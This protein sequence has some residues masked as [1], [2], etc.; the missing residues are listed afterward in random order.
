MKKVK[1]LAL[2][3][4]IELKYRIGCIPLFWQLFKNLY[5]LGHELVVVPYAGKDL[6]TL[7]WRSYPNPCYFQFRVFKFALDVKNKRK[8]KKIRSSTLQPSQKIPQSKIKIPFS[9]LTKF[10]VEPFWKKRIIE[11]FRQEKDFDVVF[12][13]NIPLTHVPSLGKFIKSRF[14]VK[15]IYY[16]GDMPVHL[17]QYGGFS[18]SNYVLDDYVLSDFDLVLSNSGGVE[19][20][21]KNFGAKRVGTLHWG[22]DPSVFSPINEKK[23]YDV[24]F[25]GYGSEFREN[26]MQ[27]LLTLPSV[28]LRDKIFVIG[29]NGF[30]KAFG[31]AKYIG[32]VPISVWR[33]KVAQS[34]INL[35]IT[36]R[37]HAV[38]PDTSTARP[39][40]LA[41]MKACIV[42]NNHVGLSQWFKIGKEILIAKDAAE[43]IEIYSWLLDDTE[44]RNQIAESAYKRVLSEHTYFHRA[45]ELIS[46]INSI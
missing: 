21:L 35:N 30:R 44:T 23:I 8:R 42:S 22:I 32:E 40:E 19:K 4:Y 33:R 16:D 14:S 31:Y 38:T 2:T 10:L 34:K 13:L 45:K 46:K 11:I 3:S 25:Y 29:G 18:T 36:R 28:R 27:Y 39:F 17:P 9:S 5:E 26:D 20:E 15:M 12:F 37:S 43:A 24:F 1:I 6:E 41:A 7:W